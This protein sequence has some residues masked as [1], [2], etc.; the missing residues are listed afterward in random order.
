MADVAPI[1]DYPDKSR[2][3][4]EA[5]RLIMELQ[6][7]EHPGKR[8]FWFAEYAETEKDARNSLAR[9]KLQE[10]QYQLS[11]EQETVVGSMEG[12]EIE[13]LAG[14]SANENGRDEEDPNI[15]GVFIG[16]DND[17]PEVEQELGMEGYFT[18]NPAIAGNRIVVNEEVLLKQPANAAE[19]VEV[20]VEG[21]EDDGDKFPIR[22]KTPRHEVKQKES[23]TALPIPFSNHPSCPGR[24]IDMM[25]GDA[26]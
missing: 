18:L 13:Q 8:P 17:I 11:L 10:E 16:N 7:E 14:T 5:L 12:L 15:E 26:R 25:G 20:Q 22:R 4:A 19:A 1:H 24:R 2:F 6:E 9:A 3:A 23:M 21:H